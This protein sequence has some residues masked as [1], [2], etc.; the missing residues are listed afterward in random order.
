M[1]ATLFQHTKNVIICAR[2]QSRAQKNCLYVHDTHAI[3]KNEKNCGTAI[4]FLTLITK[5]ATLYKLGK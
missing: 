3:L 2:W 4:F 1:S 5:N